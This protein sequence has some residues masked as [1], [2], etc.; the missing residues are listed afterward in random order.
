MDRKR[1]CYILIGL[2]ILLPVG[3][4][5]Y[6]AFWPSTPPFKVLTGLLVVGAPEILFLV[7]VALLGKEG[8]QNIKAIFRSPAPDDT[9]TVSKLRYYSGLVY[10]LLNGLLVSLYAYVPQWMPA[11]P[12]QYYILALTDI[13]FILGI[14]LMGGEFWEK[15]R[16]LFIWEGKT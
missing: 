3:A 4:L 11:A 8:I 9:I 1:A 12:T 6:T 10:C 15:F 16:K 7:A 2:A 5:V 13:C 14:F